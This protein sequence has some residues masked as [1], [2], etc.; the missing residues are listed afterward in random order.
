MDTERVRDQSLDRVLVGLSASY[1]RLR[2]KRLSPS[3]LSD[4][5]GD[6]PELWPQ[7]LMCWFCN[8]I[9]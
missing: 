6:L 5:P 7:A 2:K 3:Y 1:I 4:I 9:E 8:L